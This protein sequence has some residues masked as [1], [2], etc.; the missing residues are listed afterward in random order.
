MNFTFLDHQ[1][2]IT[3]ESH[4]QP[5]VHTFIKFRDGSLALLGILELCVAPVSLVRLDV[6]P[7]VELEDIVFL[8]EEAGSELKRV[9]SF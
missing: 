6:V 3:P 7:G 5:L 8:A 1:E 9:G 4:G 2:S